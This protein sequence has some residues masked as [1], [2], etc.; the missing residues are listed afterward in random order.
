M[1]GGI[2]GSRIGRARGVPRRLNTCTA[3]PPPAVPSA[4]R[5]AAGEDSLAVSGDLNR[6]AG[7]RPPSAAICR[8]LSSAYFAFPGQA[9]TA[10][11]AFDASACSAAQSVSLREAVRTMTSLAMSM[12]AAASAGA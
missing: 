3:R 8:R 11:Q 5:S 2:A 4:I 12:P 1:A 9:S 6:K 10:P 7:A